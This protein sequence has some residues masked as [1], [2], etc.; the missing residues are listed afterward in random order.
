MKLDNY[1]KERIKENF[2]QA[3]IKISILEL[4]LKTLRNQGDLCKFLTKSY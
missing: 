1:K 3:P 2:K 4:H